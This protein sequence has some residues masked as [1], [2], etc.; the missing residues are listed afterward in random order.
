M[1]S[2]TPVRGMKR[3]WSSAAISA[4]ASA[5]RPDRAS[6]EASRRLNEALQDDFVL[7][8][9]GADEAKL[10]RAARAVL[11]EIDK[12]EHVVLLDPEEEAKLQRAVSFSLK[13][14]ASLLTGSIEEDQQDEVLKRA[15]IALGVARAAYDE[16]RKYAGERKQFGKPIG[17]FQA[18]RIHLADMATELVSA[19]M[20]PPFNMS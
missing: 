6:A 3:A 11:V 7:L 1:R 10:E 20:P 18:V 4:T 14:M 2:N 13:V 17:K 9:S 12:V 15:R 19:Y 16:A 5:P 8:L